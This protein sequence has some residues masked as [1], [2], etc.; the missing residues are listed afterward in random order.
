M[1]EK[2]SRYITAV[3]RACATLSG[4]ILLFVTGAIFVDVGLRYFFDRPSIWVTEISSYLFL[5]II[6]LGV[7]YALDQGLH[8]RVT[9]ALDRLGPM[10]NRILNSITYFFSLIFALVLLW[11]TSI[12][13]YEAY[14]GSWTTPTLLSTPYAYIYVVMIVGSFILVITF[15][16]HLLLAVTGA[17]QG[18]GK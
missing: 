16:S 18:T 12:M 13:T 6:F 5:Y 10:A 1:L 4:L 15:L 3:N 11:Q 7:S 8:I 14:S 17:G 9:F 2:L